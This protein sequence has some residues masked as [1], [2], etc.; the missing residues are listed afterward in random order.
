MRS[1]KI[2]SLFV[3]TLLL[4][5]AIV[6]PVQAAVVYNYQV[7]STSYDSVM[8]LIKQI[9]GRTAP[10]PTPIPAPAPKPQPA[11]APVPQPAPSPQ[12]APAPQPAPSPTPA[13]DQ[14]QISAFEM[15]V[16]DLVNQERAKVGLK[17]LKADIPLTKGARM[18]SQDMRDKGYFSHTSPTYGSPF[19]MM[20]KLGIKWSAAGEN[21]ASGYR[22]PESVMQGWMNSPGHKKNILSTKWTKIGVGYAKGGK[23]GHYWTQWFTN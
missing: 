2:L 22:T 16:I 9:M 3:V 8:D 11:P 19:Q 6:T 4:F 14:S 15:R 13:P 18:K 1:K 5:V 12:P 17:P 10:T 7:Y 21:I 23:S 20:T